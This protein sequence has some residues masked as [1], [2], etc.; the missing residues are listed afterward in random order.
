MADLDLMREV[1]VRRAHRSSL[2]SQRDGF[3]GGCARQAMS[4][5][6]KEKAGVP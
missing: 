1:E 4:F 5:K 2:P 3:F 6:E